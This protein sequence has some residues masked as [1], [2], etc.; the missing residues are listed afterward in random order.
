MIK[1]PWVVDKAK[2]KTDERESYDPY[3][4]TTE[5]VRLRKEYFGMIWHNKSGRYI[6]T[7]NLFCEMCLPNPVEATVADHII[8]RR[9]GGKDDILNLQALCPR[10][11]M[12][13]TIL[14]RKK[15]AR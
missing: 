13:K 6:R 11:H 10:C 14:D 12:K 5:W 3:Y 8:P 7:K 1:R 4:N 9:A 2:P 15:Y